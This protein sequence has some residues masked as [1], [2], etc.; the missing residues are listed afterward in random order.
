MKRL[1]LALAL[2][3][4]LTVPTNSADNYTQDTAAGGQTTLRASDATTSK[5]PHVI[6]S[7]GLTP[8]TGSSANV[9]NASAVATLTATATTTAHIT[10]FQ[11]T[12]TGATAASA[13]AVTVAGVITGTMNYTVAP[14]AGATLGMTPLIVSFPIPVPASA[15]NTN[16]VVTMAAL[17]AGNTNATCAAQGFLL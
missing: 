9:A 12:A 10:G 3:L 2:G 17:G 6:V 16:I 4:A 1:L 11:C 5:I 13:K 7:S 15:V 8:V 14:P